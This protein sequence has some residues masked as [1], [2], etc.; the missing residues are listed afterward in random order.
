MT[1][2]SIRKLGR[3]ADIF[4]MAVFMGATLTLGAAMVGF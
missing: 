1:T 2:Q 4:G 3:F